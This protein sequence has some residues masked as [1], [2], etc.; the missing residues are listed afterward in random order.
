M[1]PQFFRFLVLSFAL[2][3]FSVGAFAQSSPLTVEIPFNFHVGNEKVSAGT[4]QVK[5][6]SD[7]SFLLR[8]ET[9]SVTV[10][11]QTPLTTEISKETTAAKLVFNRYENNYFLRQVFS[12]SATVGRAL[13]ESKTE[14]RTRQGLQDNEE[15]A[16]KSKPTQVAVQMKTN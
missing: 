13:Y 1:K 3:I 10:L 6:I 11:A 9:G 15:T 16:K 12:S 8:N 2:V 14:K 4:Y 7:K 5:R